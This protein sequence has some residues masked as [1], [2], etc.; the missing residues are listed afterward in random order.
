MQKNSYIGRFAPTPTGPL[1]QGSLVAALA[2]YLDAHHH[3]GTWLL[4]MEDLDPP[5]EDKAARE[6]IPQQLLAHGLKWHGAMT[7]Q[8]DNYARYESV[9]T[10][11]K[12]KQLLFPCTCS[13]KMLAVHS[14]LHLGN[15]HSFNQPPSIEQLNTPHAW[16]LPVP[17]QTYAFTDDVYGDCGHNLLTVGDQVLK[18]KDE[19]Y[20]YQLAVVVDDHYSGIN[21]VVRGLDLLDN[22][23][24]QLYLMSA[25]NYSPPH[26]MHLPLVINSDGQKLSKQNKAQALDLNT[27]EQNLLRALASLNQPM[28]PAQLTTH[29]HTILK[30]AIQHWAPLKIPTSRAGIV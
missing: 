24:R 15:C 28:P 4:R 6:L 13:R 10:Q 29:N 17:N 3:Q 26:Y 20:A 8:S 16:R 12:G 23:P 30:W 14:G 18:R 9:L 21:H 5:R 25:L 22:T 1:H 2:S 11:L 19:L 7:F 27:T